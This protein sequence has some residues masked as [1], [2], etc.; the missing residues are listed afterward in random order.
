MV[1][2]LLRAENQER[3]QL[4]KRKAN[5]KK[6]QPIWRTHGIIAGLVLLILEDSEKHGYYI[7]NPDENQNTQTDKVT[8][9]YSRD[10]TRR[11]RFIK[12]T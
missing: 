1:L 11:V 6:S 8:E 2:F 3:K 10:K 9:I 7:V 4:L 12:G 5:V